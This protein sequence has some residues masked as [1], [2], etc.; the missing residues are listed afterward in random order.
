[1]LPA[2]ERA[3]FARASV[4]IA[5]TPEAVADLQARHPDAGVRMREVPNGFED[6][7][8]L[9]RAVPSPSRPITILHSG[10]L[11][12]DRPLAPLLRV[13]AEPP[14]RG[15]FRLVLHGYA[16]PAVEA[17]IG[18]SGAAVDERPPPSD[19][20]DAVD[21]IARADVALVT[22]GRGAGDATAVASKVY[23]YLALGRPVLCVTDGGATE[24]LLRRLG[25][26]SLVA[27]LDRE[28]TIR[29]RSTGS[30][31]LRPGRARRAVAYAARNRRRLP[32]SWT[33]SSPRPR[34]ARV[35]RR[36]PPLARQPLGGQSR[37]ADGAGPRA[38]P[39][40]ARP[41]SARPPRPSQ[42]AA[43]PVRAARTALG[44]QRGQLG[45]ALGRQARAA[46]SCPARP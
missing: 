14:Y 34:F 41:R 23:E 31:A 27:R 3:T 20:A 36:R 1:M 38:S 5:C 15:A 28:E 46:C 11:T 2:L 10:T 30:P 13:L 37:S 24:A 26:D 16:A 21:R 35:A 42:P 19:W 7:L 18:R 40:P 39:R 4:V 12:A 45:D 9:R 43:A 29:L 6:E 33:R 25:A 32:R 17:E 8:L 22:Q 44:D